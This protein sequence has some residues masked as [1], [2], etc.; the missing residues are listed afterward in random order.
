MLPFNVASGR[1]EPPET[2]SIIMET[3]TIHNHTDPM[4]ITPDHV[5]S[6]KTLMGT[7]VGLMD[8]SQKNRVLSTPNSVLSFSTFH[9]L[10][11]SGRQMDGRHKLSARTQLDNAK[12]IVIET[13]ATGETFWRW[14]PRARGV[15]NASEEGTFPRRVLVGG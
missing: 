14:V 9:P 3:S 15:S 6:I 13:L 10:T 12:R 11:A 8:D 7:T 1:P 5:P 4:S 2:P